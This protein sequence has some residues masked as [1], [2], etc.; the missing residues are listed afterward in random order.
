TQTL[1]AREGL[2]EAMRGTGQRRARLAALVARVE[3]LGE[4]REAIL[5]VLEPLAQRLPLD[6]LHVTAPLRLGELKTQGR[7]L[8]GLVARGRAG[9]RVAIG[10]RRQLDEGHAF[11][12][13]RR[14]D[15]RHEQLEARR[16]VAERG[17]DLDASRRL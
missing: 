11:A 16:L 5:G 13:Q 10:A 17:V 15:H 9:G 4:R 2:I 1:L 3:L 12:R 6:R 8:L 14:A 7:E